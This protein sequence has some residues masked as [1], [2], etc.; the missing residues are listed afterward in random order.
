M[1]SSTSSTTVSGLSPNTEY[2]IYVRSIC[3]STDSSTWAGPISSQTFSNDAPFLENFDAIASIQCWT[4]SPNDV[5]DWT[6]NSMEEQI[7]IHWTL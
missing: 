6:L 7:Q 2:D 5:F 3:G 4:Q 1:S